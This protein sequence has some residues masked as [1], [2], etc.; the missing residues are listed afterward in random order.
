[1][2]V[3]NEKCIPLEL[4]KK[5]SQEYSDCWDLV[6][7]FRNSRGDDIPYW[8]EICYIPISA[9]L[10]ITSGGSM[11]INKQIKQK[12]VSDAGLMAAIA[13]WRL[14]K[15]IYEFAP[16][17]ESMLF[18]QADD[19]KIPVEVLKNLPYPCIYISVKT[20][21]SID[22]FFVYVESDVN[23]GRLELRLLIVKDDE[24]F[25]PIII[26]L[27]ERATLYDGIKEAQKEA[28]RVGKLNYG[29]IAIH[30]IKK[31]D[32][33][34]DILLLAAPIL[35]MVLYICAQNTE[36]K[37]DK[38][39]EKIYRMPKSREYIKDKYSE[40]RKYQCGEEFA[41]KIRVTYRESYVNYNYMKASSGV[42]S[43]KSP[44]VRRGHWHHYWSGKKDNKALI[45]KWQPPTFIHGDKIN[46]DE[47]NV[48]INL[49]DNTRKSDKN[50]RKQKE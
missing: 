19:C 36:I 26:H 45:L 27:K 3:N 46:P 32:L 37:P 15:Q 34:D 16:E 23:T 11:D 13:P 14:Y 18:D 9:T 48:D 44:H 6:E 17:T 7:M 33:A 50:E 5:I 2:K 29:D 21:K 43:S 1:M 42:G 10:A 49:I 4:T 30:Q 47:K 25:F 12:V 31:E 40:I 22:G 8:D 38:I 39:Q 20:I 35:Q 24:E 41:K 28:I